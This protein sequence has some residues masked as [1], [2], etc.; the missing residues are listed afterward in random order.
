A[1]DIHGLRDRSGR[2]L[3]SDGIED[4]QAL[5]GHNV[6]LTIDKGIQFTA[7]RELE[8]AIKTYEA[9]GGSIVVVDPATGEILALASAPGFNPND[10]S[11]ADPDSRRNRAIADRFE[12]GSS[13]KV[14][15]MASA[16]AAKSVAPSATIYCEE[17]T[18]AVDN[19]VIHDT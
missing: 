19:I 15:M 18:M 16:L 11:T 1:S 9:I 14:F 3:F 17:G 2:V 5:A 10:Y 8:A 7:E 6:Y 12:P 13:M 4:E